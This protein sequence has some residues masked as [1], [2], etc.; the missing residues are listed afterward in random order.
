MFNLTLP[1]FEAALSDAT[2]HVSLKDR[3]GVIRSVALTAIYSYSAEDEFNNESVD[4]DKLYLGN[5]DVLQMADF[6]FI[7]LE[8]IPQIIKLE[9]KARED[10]EL[11]SALATLERAA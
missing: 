3:T 1:K 11:E 8:I 6:N 5:V 7:D 4:L 9:N 10:I 2:V